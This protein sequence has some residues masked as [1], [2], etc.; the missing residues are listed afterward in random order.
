MKQVTIY[1]D[2]ACSGNPGPGGYGAILAYGAHSRELS[3]GYART[4]NNRM[5]ILAAIVALETLKEPCEVTLYSDSKYLTQAISQ[6]WL[7]GWL[8]NGW[9]T[10]TKKPVKNIDLW[11]RLNAQLHRHKVTFEWV[12]GHAENANNNRCDELARTA[13]K[14]PNLLTDVGF[15]A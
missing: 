2:G 7:L 10:T 13:A 9:K 3:A 6:H 8:R 11:Q 14:A 15:E 5:E 1:T 12:K 4:T